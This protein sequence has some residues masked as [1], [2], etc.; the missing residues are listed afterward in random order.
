MSYIAPI[1]RPSSIREAIR[2]RLWEGEEVLVTAYV[3][4]VSAFI[5]FQ[6]Y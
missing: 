3:S 6:P 5:S 2:I 4:R 1:H